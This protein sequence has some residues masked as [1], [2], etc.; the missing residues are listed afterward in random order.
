MSRVVNIKYGVSCTRQEDNIYMYAI[1]QI[2]IYVR[3]SISLSHANRFPTNNS[4]SRHR[5]DDFFDEDLPQ[6]ILFTML[7]RRSQNV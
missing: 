1:C 4:K 2:Y 7:V 5:V 6:V 3:R